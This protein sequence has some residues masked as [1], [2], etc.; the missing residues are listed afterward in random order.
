M[1]GELL[2][3]L[4]VLVLYGLIIAVSVI[5]IIFFRDFRKWILEFRQE[6]LNQR[7][8]L[9]QIINLLS[10]ISKKNG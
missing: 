9:N 2:G 4:F 3:A 10:E 7:I 5:T 8:M 1:L 6:Q